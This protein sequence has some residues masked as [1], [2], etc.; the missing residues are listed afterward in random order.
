M[1]K[2]PTCHKLFEGSLRFCQNDGTPL[3]DEAPPVDPY[4]TVVAGSVDLSPVNDPAPINEPD[5]VLDLPSAS[6]PLKTMYVSE[7]EMREA[8]GG[9]GHDSDDPNMEI[10]GLTPQ[11]PRFS[12]PQLV[13]PKAEDVAPPPSPFTPS[14][15][16][17]P[18]APPVF[19]Q[20]EPE[21][22]IQQSPKIDTP[23]F[24]S[25]FD[26]PQSPPAQWTPPPAPVAS[27]DNSPI[28]SNTPFAPPP[29]GIAAGEDK[30]LAI[31]SLVL[32]ILGLI[33]CGLFAGIPAIITGFIAKKRADTEPALY[34]G[35]GM[36][37]AGIVLGGISIIF[38]VIAILLNILG[39][40]ANM[41]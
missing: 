25:P 5:D 29:A 6:D 16:P 19:S 4:K 39:V 17:P 10:P 15:E 11:Q 21:T 9:V 36:A 22:V 31:V 8:M 13:T 12:E 1:K 30:T 40:F 18:V 2:C 32:G 35:R 23:N 33:C 3:I 38:T 27:W 41:R 14:F 34:G 28:G 7:S 37:T 20:P 24:G 26:Q